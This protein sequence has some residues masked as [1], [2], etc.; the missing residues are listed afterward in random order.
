MRKLPWLN[1]KVSS[2]FSIPEI[3]HLNGSALLPCSSVQV[4]GR[5]MTRMPLSQMRQVG[6]LWQLTAHIGLSFYR[7]ERRIFLTRNGVTLSHLGRRNFYLFL[8]SVV[9]RQPGIHIHPLWLVELQRSWEERL[10]ERDVP[11]LL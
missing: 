6:S 11:Q 4:V 1:F 9:F 8:P 5:S 3:M 10:M 7:G 2:S